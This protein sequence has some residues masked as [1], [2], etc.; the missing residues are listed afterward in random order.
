MRYR[1]KG[2]VIATFTLSF[3]GIDSFQLLLLQDA[4]SDDKY[5]GKLKIISSNS[6]FLAAV[7][8]IHFNFAIFN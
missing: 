7:G 4:I 6:T 2:S 1:R 8:T 5:I 3:A